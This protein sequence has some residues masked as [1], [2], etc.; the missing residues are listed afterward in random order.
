MT[1]IRNVFCYDELEAPIADRI[2]PNLTRGHALVFQQRHNI[3]RLT[4]T[5]R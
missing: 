1:V 3:P 5:L 2:A 4:L